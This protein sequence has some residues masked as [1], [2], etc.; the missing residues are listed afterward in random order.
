M[1]GEGVGAGT[2]A[3]V[4]EVLVKLAAT[5]V[6]ALEY[7][8]AEYTITASMSP[9]ADQEVTCIVL[10]CSSTPAPPAPAKKPRSP[11]V[12]RRD[13]ACER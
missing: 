8:L 2:D 9:A 5:S 13:R 6:A 1:V 4:K 10:I 3:G 11:T 12:R 7:L